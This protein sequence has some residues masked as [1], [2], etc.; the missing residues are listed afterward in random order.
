MLSDSNKTIESLTQEHF[1]ETISEIDRR[2]ATY[3]MLLNEGFLML[4]SAPRPKV[5]VYLLSA[6]AFRSLRSL[7]V[8]LPL[9][10][11]EACWI[12]IRTSFEA[13]ILGAH[14]SK[15]EVD[16]RRW[17]NGERISMRDV[18]AK[19]LVAT[20]YRLWTDLCN[21]VHPNISG[22]HARPL[23][24]DED[25]EPFAFVVTDP[26]EVEPMFQPEECEHLLFH[27]DVEICK[28]AMLQVILFRNTILDRSMNLSDRVAELYKHAMRL[29]GRPDLAKKIKEIEREFGLD[30]M[31]RKSK[32]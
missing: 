17:L 14:L 11:Y 10:H 12:L 8:L 13:T 15:N 5:P 22:L 25:R 6:K 31:Y 2:L 27:M 32:V 23:K 1:G 29:L 26:P 18:K 9:G 30:L 19:G 20:W 3:E 28:G 4:P 7:R 16:S 24:L 21:K